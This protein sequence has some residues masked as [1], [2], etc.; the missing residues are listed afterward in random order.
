MQLSGAHGWGHRP[1]ALLLPVQA[2]V[3]GWAGRTL[4][5]GRAASVPPTMPHRC[6]A[7]ELGQDT[8][9]RGV[10][11]ID[12]VNDRVVAGSLKRRWP[13]VDHFRDVR[14]NC[15]PRA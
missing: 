5:G 13:V 7:A 14:L 4:G 9:R 6:A 3:S 8:A 1:G 12:G 15:T 10:Q 11:L 2:V